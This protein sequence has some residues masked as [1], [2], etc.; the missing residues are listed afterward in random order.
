MKKTGV[1]FFLLGSFLSAFA[2]NIEPKDSIPKKNNLIFT[3]GINSSYGNLN[4]KPAKYINYKTKTPVFIIG[5][6]ARLIKS[7]KRAYI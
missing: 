3:L 6:Q 2:S 5:I 1:I 4:G 7:I